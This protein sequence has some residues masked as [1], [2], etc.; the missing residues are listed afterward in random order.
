MKLKKVDW[1]KK[2]L[3][4]GILFASTAIGVSH[5]VQST[6][7]GA[8]Y[9]FSLLIFILI[10]NIFK[11][12]FFEFASRFS[13]ATE[14][15]IIEGY[16]ILG[17]KIV[18][19]YLIITLVSMFFISSAV[20]AVTAGFLQNLFHTSQFGIINHI[21]IFCICGSILSF[22]K[23]S[24]LDS[25]IKI[26]GFTLLVSTLISFILVLSK[27]PINED[28]LPT[29]HYT[30]VD[31][32]FIIALM[33][34]MPTAVDLSSW[35]SLWTLERIKDSNYKPKLKETLFEFNLGYFASAILSI[36]FLTLGAYLMYGSD[37][38][39]SN[40][41]AIFANQVIKLYTAS[42]GSWSYLIISISSFS[43]MFGTCI[44]VFDGYAR[45][46][47]ECIRLVKSNSSN[48]TFYNVII[49]ILIV[50]SIF[51]IYFFGS[52]L[53]QL[54]DLATTISFLIAPF[55]AVANYLL[56]TKH[57]DKNMQPKKWLR[58][59]AMIGILYLVGFSLLFIYL[60]IY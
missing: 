50:G 18:W 32:L 43:I 56:V 38:S 2:T 4:P 15:S 13:N 45:S 34:W 17:K 41:S 37:S 8:N 24:S 39:F 35:N 46:A 28:I 5:L 21:I 9:G 3:G 23:Y 57:I 48:K 58:I 20:G 7:A 25:L 6:R 33:G 55:V 14:K 44:A 51:I 12:P 59:L 49:W 40:N 16:K 19:I 52:K 1:L 30:K 53:K 31:I 42:I 27:G 36:C 60:K 10:A 26:I 47:N 22:G 54:V 29:I 11:Y